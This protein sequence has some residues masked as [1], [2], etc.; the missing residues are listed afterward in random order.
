MADGAAARKSNRRERRAAGKGSVPPG[1]PTT[2]VTSG[3]PQPAGSSGTPQQAPSQPSVWTWEGFKIY[4]QQV[5]LE[6][7]RV[8]WPTR[9]E[10]QAATTVVMF[11][12]L[13]FAGYLGIL[14]FIL[15][16]VFR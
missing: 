11:T 15:K 8:T 7:N 9:R 5:R 16:R 12:L 14:D 13:I 3:A 2:T 4:L 1:G 10:L 6:M